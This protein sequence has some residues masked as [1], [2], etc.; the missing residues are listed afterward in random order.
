M[1]DGCNIIQRI[2]HI[3]L[4]TLAPTITI[5]LILAAGGIL[6]V[7]FEK[8]FL[9][10]NQ[11]NKGVSE[12]IST[13]VYNLSLGAAGRP[14]FSYAAGVGMF[15]SVINLIILLSVNKIAEKIN[16]NSFF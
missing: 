6:S 10:Q 9:M 11:V 3:E 14:N 12:V 15:Q 16:G 8:V 2:R 5:L 7:G 4:P 13:Y 1:I